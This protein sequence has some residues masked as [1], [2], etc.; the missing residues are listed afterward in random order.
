MVLTATTSSSVNPYMTYDQFKTCESVTSLGAKMH[1]CYHNVSTATSL[2][3]EF[4]AWIKNWQKTS[5]AS[6]QR[7]KI[8]IEHFRQRLNSGCCSPSVGRWGRCSRWSTRAPASSAARSWAWRRSW[9]KH[10]ACP[11]SGCWAP[12]SACC[13]GSRCSAPRGTTCAEKAD[14]AKVSR[15][16]FVIENSF[17]RTDHGTSRQR[18]SILM[19]L[20]QWIIARS[21]SK[22]GL[23]FSSNSFLGKCWWF[24]TF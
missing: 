5:T 1:L 19:S 10:A 8:E 7:R 13:P 15:S 16:T 3:W 6:K 12:A 14:E 18:C 23:Y 4:R 11:R 17:K 9:R 21:V 24:W 2:Q 22:C 20:V